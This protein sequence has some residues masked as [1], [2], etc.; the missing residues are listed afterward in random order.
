MELLVPDACPR[1]GELPGRRPPED[2]ITSGD[3]TSVFSILSTRKSRSVRA[4][5][6]EFHVPNA[7]ETA[8][9]RRSA[10]AAVLLA[11]NAACGEAL[12]VGQ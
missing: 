12:I 10:A 4:V 3:G 1:R 11:G 2:R 5:Q 9:K 8:N 6:A 7:E